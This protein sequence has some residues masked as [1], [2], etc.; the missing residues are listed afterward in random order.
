MR[1]EVNGKNGH[2]E[3]KTH[4]DRNLMVGYVTGSCPANSRKVIEE[5]CLDCLDCRTQLSILLH[6][7]IS[8]PNAE[9]HRK[10]TDLLSLGEAAAARARAIIMMQQ[11]QQQRRSGHFSEASLG[12]A[13]RIRRPIL[14]PALIIF[15]LI[16]GS[17]FA[18]FISSPQSSEER[19]LVRMRDVY[20]NTRLL[21]ARV[22]GG[23]AHQNYVVT[24]GSGDLTGVDETQRIAL[25]AEINQEVHTRPK[26]ATRH[27]LGK[28]LM[29]QGD[30]D[31]AEQQFLLAIK[32]APRHARLNADLGALYFERSRKNEHADR[33]VLEK[34]SEYS[35]NAVEIDPELPE[36]WFN[37]AL[38]YERMNLPLLA[39]SDWKQ[40]LTL[41]NNSAWADEAR[42][43]L[44]KLRERKAGLEKLEQNVP[45][46][47]QSAAAAGDK[48]KM[49]EL[50]TRH[51]VLVQDLAIDQIFDKYLAAAI[52]G[53]RNNADIH[54]RALKQI[55][56][57]I[58]ETKGDRFV[59]DAVNLVMRGNPAVKK[60]V[61]AIRQTLQQAKQ[62]HRRGNFGMAFTLY[63]NARNS[64]ERIGD[65]CHA[66]MADFGLAFIYRHKDKSEELARLRTQLIRDS[67]R[68]DHR[69]MHARAL[70]A[71][72]NVEGGAQQLSLNLEHSSQSAKIAK[73]LGDAQT[74]VYSLRFVGH[75]YARLGDYDP[76]LK[77]LSEAISL[78]SNPGVKPLNAAYTFA[79]MGDTL[80]RMGKYLTALPYQHEAVRICEQSDNAFLLAYM[81]NGLGV[82]YGMLGRHKEAMHY[83]NDAVARAEAISDPVAR[84]QLQIDIYTRFGEFYLQQNKASEAI[85][86][87]RRAIEKIGRENDRYSLSTIHKGLATA[88]LAQGKDPEAEAELEKSIRLTE[89]AREQIDDARARGTFLASQQSI[90]RAMASFQFFNKKDPA[91]AFNYA[92]IAKARDLLDTLAGSPEVSTNDGQVK[93]AISRS[94]T[95]LTLEQVQRALP[96]NAQLVQYVIGEKNLM[97]WLVTRDRLITANANVSADDLRT[98]VTAYLDEL[99]KR[100]E[101]DG[102]NSRAAE[103]YRWL[104]AP[105]GKQLDPKSELCIVPDGLLQNLPFAALVSPETK[106]YLIEDF[107]LV[108]NPSA[109]VFA[110]TLE[111]SCDKQLS[112]SG[113]FLGLANP[114]F[115]QQHFPK[116]HPLPSSEEELERIQSF[117]S[118]RRILS[119]GQATE[120]SLVNQIGKYEIVHLATHALSDKQ[121]SLFSA[122]VLAD[123]GDGEQN[124]GKV[125]FDGALRAHEIY[126]LKPERT[127]LVLLSSC[128]SGLGNQTRNEAMGGLA[129]AF[130]VAG[131]PTVMAS[132]WDIDDESTAALMERLHATHRMKNLAFGQSLRQAQISYLQSAPARRRHP[133]FWATFIVT[134]NGLTI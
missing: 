80:F 113:S 93:L 43:H 9:E 131:V 20:G 35:S 83:H 12:K 14:A 62:E 3:P 13:L 114:R 91:R 115:N 105:I 89:E 65:Y 111:L 8:S 81:T 70:L 44:T 76:A 52:S 109:S 92:E 103:L 82:T 118:D 104:I 129:Q 33:G 78:S 45:A 67:E 72:A 55:G 96:A 119:R 133:Y 128:S 95:P 2:K 28:L 100:G 30:L 21:Q 126:R 120:S 29:L 36:A 117:Y 134:G 79:E 53:D 124:S 69:Q 31:P 19:M 16:T 130:L 71:L 34:A 5:H 132:L 47:F 59:T 11:E 7:I 94:A 84:V 27:I 75:A 87:Y 10:F 121:S 97:I 107:S 24:R 39:K 64:A 56:Q 66:E 77:N 123:E 37:R 112:G 41:D 57:L 127:R 73:E 63:E 46:E 4:P 54:L 38:C 26:A 58:S 18:Y 50:I 68:R 51:F 122:I 101:I 40:F 32:E 61:Q 60:E 108:T 74:A 17:L 25:L 99:R 15:V 98:K 42:A 86:T 90:Y 49:R 102:L 125:A 88:Y 85:A 22:T 110:R 23:F 106:R 116:L 48:P 6:L 1:E